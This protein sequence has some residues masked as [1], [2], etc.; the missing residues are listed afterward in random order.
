MSEIKAQAQTEPDPSATSLPND[1]TLNPA[2]SA[3]ATTE[4]TAAPTIS[5]DAVMAEKMTAEKH[6]ESGTAGDNDSKTTEE[7]KEDD[8]ATEEM[9][10]EDSRHSRNG[11]SR[12]HR[13]HN[14][15]NGFGARKKQKRNVKS[16]YDDL[17]ESSD[18]DE[19]RRQVESTFL[20]P[21]SP[22]TDSFSTR[23][24]ATATD[25]ST[26]RKS[27]TSS[28]CATSNHTAQCSRQSRPAIC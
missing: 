20:I 19:I 6:T 1:Q 16:N 3:D 23:L 9:D 26:S 15:S 8:K 10:I 24:A 22:P 28:A 7:V 4:V 2:P 27:T 12:K 25:L 11:D 13:D 18:A 21:T 17:P 14:D 5:E